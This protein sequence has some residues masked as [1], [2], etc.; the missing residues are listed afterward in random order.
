MNFLESAFG[1][2]AAEE[3][4]IDTEVFDASGLISSESEVSSNLPIVEPL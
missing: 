3:T 4:G 2:V 1:I